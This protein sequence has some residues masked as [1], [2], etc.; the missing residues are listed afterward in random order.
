MSMFGACELQLPVAFTNRVTDASQ[1]LL[2]ARVA[3]VFAVGGIS[4]LIVSPCGAAPLAS[5]RVYLSQTRDVVLGGS[6]LFALAAGMSVPLLLIGASAVA[7][8]PR[9]GAWMNEVKRFFGVMLLGVALWTVQSVLPG[10]L[11]LGLWGA[12]TMCAA[13]LVASSHAARDLPITRSL[14]RRVVAAVLAACGLLQWAGAASGG[15]NLLQPLAHL[16]GSGRAAPRQAVRFE[17][18]RNVAELDAVLKTAGRPVVLDFY[19]EWCVSC[20]EMLRFTYADPAVRRRMSA[21]L[22]LKADVTANGEQGHALL[23]R[24]G[25]FGPPCTI[26]FDAQVHELM[27]ARVVG[28]QN[29]QTFLRALDAA[30]R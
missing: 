23:R 13:V 29:T 4:A 15:A 6:A 9:K 26:F 12:L 8:L 30:G 28:Y 17:A 11:A 1:S 5:A 20:K 10:S 18:A 7:L 2:A 27:P 25:L 3:G 16:A 19:A 22:L 14:W 24:F 21:A